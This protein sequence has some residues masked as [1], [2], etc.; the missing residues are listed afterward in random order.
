MISLVREL[1]IHICIHQIIYQENKFSIS[2]WN[3]LISFC[4]I[5]I[6]SR[7]KNTFF[8]LL[9][10]QHHQTSIELFFMDSI[11]MYGKNI[12]MITKNAI[13]GLCERITN[14]TG[15]SRV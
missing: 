5:I 1:H 15:E 11:A 9:H 2:L 3:K 8:P 12:F 13:I 10:H 6:I 14:E 7:Y 4:I